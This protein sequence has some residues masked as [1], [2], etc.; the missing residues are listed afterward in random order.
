MARVNGR[1]SRADVPRWRLAA[2]LAPL[3]VLATGG[4][5]VLFPAYSPG[6]LGLLVLCEAALLA[7]A[8]ALAVGP[9]WRQAGWRAAYSGAVLAVFAAFGAVVAWRA[10]GGGVDLATRFAALFAAAL[11]AGTWQGERLAGVLFSRARG[12]G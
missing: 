12:P 4:F 7:W 2:L 10:Q 6:V 5:A 8:V 11:L 9:G 1:P 3:L